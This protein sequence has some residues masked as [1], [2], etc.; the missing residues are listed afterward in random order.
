MFASRTVSRA[1]G[2]LLRRLARLSLEVLRALL[3]GTAS[4]GP[5][6]PPPE[7]PPPQTTEQVT[8][9]SSEA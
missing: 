3:I 1:L 2:H 7:P 6:R 8:Q 4:F 5:P 9:S